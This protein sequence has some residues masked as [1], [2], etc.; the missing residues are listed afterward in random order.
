MNRIATLAITAGLCAATL[1]SAHALSETL[2]RPKI[3]W[4]QNYDT[5]TAAQVHRVLNSD[6][7]RYLDGIT[8][9]WEPRWP[10]TLAYDG[11]AQALSAF[12]KALND[13]QGINVRLTL[14]RDLSKES[15]GSMAAGSWWVEY[16][17]T[18]PDT[19]TLRINL[20]AE[21]LGAEK[22]ELPLPKSRPQ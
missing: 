11:D 19:L 13:V 5:N 12:I 21:A 14:S 7:F 8:S 10:T 15:R 22:F 3:F 17:H 2:H 6:K 16:S 20:A 18:M 4:P 1:P 9:Y